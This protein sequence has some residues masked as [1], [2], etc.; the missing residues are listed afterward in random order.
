MPILF[1]EERCLWALQS[2]FSTYGFGVDGEGRLRH[3]YHGAALLRLGDL[4]EPGPSS[5]PQHFEPPGGPEVRYEYPAW[6][7]IFYGEPCLKATFSDGVRDVRLLYEGHE[8][9]DG[10]APKLTVELRDAP[11][12]PIPASG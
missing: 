5:P 11:G 7:G 3:L 2:D 8:V 4:P 6:G 9:R 12:W 1:D 10:A